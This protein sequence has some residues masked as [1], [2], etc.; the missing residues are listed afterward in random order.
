MGLY[1][2]NNPYL[3]SYRQYG[4]YPQ[5][6][7][8]Q[9]QQMT[10]QAPTLSGRMVNNVNEISAN[11]VPMN[12]PVSVFPKNDLSEIY[13][14]SWNANGTISTVVYKPCAEPQA[15]NEGNPTAAFTEEVIQRLEKIESAIQGIV[16]RKVDET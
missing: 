7:N 12:A 14:K 5:M 6:G 3:A 4:T 10:Q 8:Y 11:D 16:T 13:A 1:D 2:Y 9:P 15:S